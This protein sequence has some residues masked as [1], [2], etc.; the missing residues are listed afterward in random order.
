MRTRC[1]H[2]SQ[3]E[4]AES[5]ERNSNNKFSMH[6]VSI[7]NELSHFSKIGLSNNKR[8]EMKLFFSK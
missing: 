8:A 6:I 7:F 5:E 1:H 2:A 3:Q 4:A